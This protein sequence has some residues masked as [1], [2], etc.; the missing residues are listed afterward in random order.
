MI[1]IK[2]NGQVIGGHLTNAEKK[3]LDI[4]ARK[5]YAEYDRKNANEID[6]IFLAYMHLRYG[7]MHDRLKQLYFGIYPEIMK[8]ADRYEMTDEGDMIFLATHLLKEIGVDI[9]AWAKEVE[10]GVE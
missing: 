8:L 1:P 9:E 7:W 6:A 3:A 5:S 10:R 2:T 4:E